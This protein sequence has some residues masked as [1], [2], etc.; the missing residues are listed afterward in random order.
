MTEQ[1]WLPIETAPKDGTE[2]VCWVRLRGG[3][4]TYRIVKWHEPGGDKDRAYW[5]VRGGGT[6]DTP[7]MGWRPLPRLPR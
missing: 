6:G 4:K 7:P 1:D 3:V 2:I 5:L